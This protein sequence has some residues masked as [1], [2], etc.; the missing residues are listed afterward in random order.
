[1]KLLIIFTITFITIYILYLL[2]VILNKKKKNKIFET[3]QAKLIIVPNKLDTNKIKKEN[4][5]QIISIANSFIVALTFTIS[6]LIDNY[7][8]KLIVSFITLIILILITYK[9]IG[10][11]YKKK[12]GK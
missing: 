5:A 9:V 12:E 7:I 1:M 8:I 4:F 3:N 11:I 6:E 10:I 2:T